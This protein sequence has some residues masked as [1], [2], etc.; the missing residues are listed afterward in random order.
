RAIQIII[1]KRKHKIIGGTSIVAATIAT[2]IALFITTPTGFKGF[3]DNDTS[4]YLGIAATEDAQLAWH[5]KNG[6]NAI[7]AYSFDS[8]ITSSSNWSKIA[9]YIK[10][11]RKKG[12]KTFGIP[13][14]SSNCI[15]SIEAYNKA[16]P[17]DSS[18]IN[19]V[20]S[21]IEP[22]NTGDYAGFYVTLRKVSDW[23]VKQSPRIERNCYMG[24][25]TAACWDSITSLT[26][27]SFIHSYLPSTKISGAACYVYMRTRLTTIAN[28]L[29]VKWKNSTDKYNV[30]M[31]N[32]TETSF[33]YNYFTTH[34]W[35][36]PQT[37]LQS[38]VSNFGDSIVKA[39]IAFGGR[40]IFVSHDGKNARP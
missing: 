2:I 39:R 5:V 32:S 36:Q 3:Y 1:M 6:D 12:I 15:A 4:T 24:W 30:V 9:N 23:A 10:K 29:A 13:Y 20:I 27:R 22:Y 31:I 28:I 40:M 18:R 38:Y 16:Q 35:D 7:Y 25:P 26:D 19:A 14:S 17:N 21:E 8:K 33:S 11:A 37:E 34:T